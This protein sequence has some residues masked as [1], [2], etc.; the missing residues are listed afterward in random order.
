MSIKYHEKISFD[1][2]GAVSVVAI[3]TTLRKLLFSEYVYISQAVKLAD[4][5]RRHLE[6]LGAGGNESEKRD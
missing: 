1:L 6:N 5:N 3:S 4:A 2:R